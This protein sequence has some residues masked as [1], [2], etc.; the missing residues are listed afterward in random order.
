MAMTM[1]ETPKT[2]FLWRAFFEIFEDEN[3]NKKKRKS[4]S[5]LR[6]TNIN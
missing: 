5:L 6:F 2:I 3:E 4:G 1:I